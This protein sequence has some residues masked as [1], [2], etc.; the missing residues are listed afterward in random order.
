MIGD[1]PENDGPAAEVGMDTF[2][3]QDGQTLAEAIAYISAKRS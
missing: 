1:D 3:L 2:I